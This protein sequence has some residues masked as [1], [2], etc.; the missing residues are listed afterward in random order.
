MVFI[1]LSVAIPPTLSD[2][3]KQA[4]LADK[5]QKGKM[6]DRIAVLVGWCRSHKA[7]LPGAWSGDEQVEDIERIADLIRRRRNEAGHPRH[8]PMR[9]TREQMY[10]HLMVFPDYCKHLYILKEWAASNPAIIT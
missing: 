1:D 8:P 10:S 5:M 9:P 6:K 3:A 2:S 7:L 4:K